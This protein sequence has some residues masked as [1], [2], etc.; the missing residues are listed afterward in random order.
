MVGKDARGGTLQWDAERIRGPVTLTPAERA[1]L[2]AYARGGTVGAATSLGLSPY[3]VRGHL[4]R[5][6]RKLGATNTTQALIA[7]LRAGEVTLDELA[8]PQ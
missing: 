3:T 7:A 4:A 8:E 5:V 2:I 6:R 1:V